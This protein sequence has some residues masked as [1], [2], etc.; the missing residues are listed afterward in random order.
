[1]RFYFILKY[2]EIVIRSI[3]FL[4]FFLVYLKWYYMFYIVFL[5]L[6]NEGENLFIRKRAVFRFGN[7]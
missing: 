1:M 4:N 5:K 7:G 3:C 6:G 2:L